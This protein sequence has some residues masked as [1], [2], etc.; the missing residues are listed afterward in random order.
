M[1]CNLSKEPDTLAYSIPA[2]HLTWEAEPVADF[3]LDGTL[4]AGEGARDKSERTDADHVLAEM[5]ADVALWPMPA[6]DALAAGEARGVHPQA[7][8][9]AALRAGVSIPTPPL[10]T[11][12]P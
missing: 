4:A 3:D 10:D 1:K 8:R 9:R 2:G 12:I 7:M 11:L 6:K 5:L